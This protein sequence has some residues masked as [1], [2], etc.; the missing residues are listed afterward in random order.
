MDRSISCFCM[1]FNNIKSINITFIKFDSYI[2]IIFNGRAVILNNQQLLSNY[3]LFQ[4]YLL[5]LILTEN[6]S[7]INNNDNYYGVVAKIWENFYLSSSYIFVLLEK[8]AHK[9]PF[10]AKEPKRPTS[11]K[12]I[13]KF[14]WI[15]NK[16]IKSININ[17]INLFH[18]Y[19]SIELKID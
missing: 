3:E 2:K 16:W 15:F 18:Q 10:N 5:S 7:K 6:T 12:K 14:M 11:S 1:H 8:T 17:P 13:N 4:I 9:N 19:C